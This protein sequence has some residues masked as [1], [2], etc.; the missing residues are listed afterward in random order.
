MVVVVVGGHFLG[1]KTP[2]NA[3]DGGNRRSE[4]GEFKEDPVKIGM[5]LVILLTVQKSGEKT[6]WDV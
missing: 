5:K 6:A 4:I 1:R 2:K 3:E